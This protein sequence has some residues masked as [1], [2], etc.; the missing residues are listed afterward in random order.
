MVSHFRL[1]L[2]LVK[3]IIIAESTFLLLNVELSS[4][5]VAFKV[6]TNGSTELERLKRGV[7]SRIGIF[8]ATDG[9]CTFRHGFCDEKTHTCRCD[10]Q[11]P[12]NDQISKCGRAVG[13][14][15]PCMFDE[16]CEH[17]V[18]NSMCRDQQCVCRGNGKEQKLPDGT[19]KCIGK[20]FGDSC[21]LDDECAFKF[22]VC[23]PYKRNCQ[24]PPDMMATDHIDKC[25]KAKEVNE[26][27][28]FNEQCE[29]TLFD[30]AC[31]DGTCQCRSERTPVKNPDGSIKCTV[32]E[33]NSSEVTTDPTMIIVLTVMC[34]MFIIICVVLHL[35]SRARWRENRTIFN[36]PNPRLMNVSLIRDKKN[37]RRGSKEGAAKGPPSREPSMASLR[38]NSPSIESKPAISRRESRGTSNGSARS[39]TSRGPPMQ[40]IYDESTLT[41][42]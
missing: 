7:D 8:C 12:A 16:Q 11:Y 31:V 38:Q 26:E 35:F 5:R 23:D 36:T 33:E 27:C 42:F 34:M 30:T 32:V 19:T 1:K 40:A 4:A 25:G 13:L 3:I 6:S 22:A 39:P 2:E 21:A 9:D 10:E 41:D 18:W 24:C 17:K 20:Q 15:L 14:G 29:Q 37:E 28:F